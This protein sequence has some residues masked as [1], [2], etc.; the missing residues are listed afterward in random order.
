[1]GNC[2]L[3]L[4]ASEDTVTELL[5]I[6]SDLLPEQ[7]GSRIELMSP[8]RLDL[9][10][11]WK[12][13]DSLPVTISWKDGG[14]NPIDLTGWFPVAQSR[15]LDLNA[16][17]TDATGGITKVCSFNALNTS[18]FRVGVEQWNW[19]WVDPD[20]VI[21]PPTFFGQIEVKQ[22]MAKPVIEIPDPRP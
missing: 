19:V 22:S 6:N 10:D 2:P 15:T 16:Q 21:Y 13:C 12:G 1:M 5:F 7:S 8:K 9:P 14:G 11:I 20:G 18:K 4:S 3:E 17:V